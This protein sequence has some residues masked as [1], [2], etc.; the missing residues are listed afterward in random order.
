MF[1]LMELP[2]KMEALEPM[3]SK[4]P[5]AFHYGKHIS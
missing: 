5:M 4:E 1:R 3:I 2:D